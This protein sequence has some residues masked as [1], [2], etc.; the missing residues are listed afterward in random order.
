M[1]PRVKIPNRNR[2]FTLVEMSL[3][4]TMIAL[5]ATMVMPSIAHWREG[6]PYRQFPGKLMQLISEAREDAIQSHT[7][8][9]LSYD[10][11]TGE[12]RVSWINPDTSLE[13][14]GAR[15]ALPD[16]IQLNRLVLEDVDTAPSAWKLTFYPDGTAD[17]GGIELQ[18]ED[19]SRSISISELGSAKL[20][21]TS[22]PEATSERWAAGDNET[23][24]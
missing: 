12:I 11:G 13:E 23:R 5:F 1:L 9:A 19:Q 3:V 4:I 7:P 14:D 15:L 21:D 24:Q 2:G 6:I 16:R 8:H 10:E 17:K 18:D 22:L 20:L